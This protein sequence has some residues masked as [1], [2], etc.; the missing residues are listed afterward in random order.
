M[1]N[2]GKINQPKEYYT[3]GIQ[4]PP[5]PCVGFNQDAGDSFKNDSTLKNSLIRLS[6]DL[7][8]IK[9]GT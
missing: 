1:L 7:T 9:K 5:P 2:L 6:K 8:S 3:G 4:V